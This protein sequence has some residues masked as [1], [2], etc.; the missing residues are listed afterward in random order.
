M[1]A[2]LFG[3]TIQNE[4]E[5]KKRGVLA[6]HDYLKQAQHLSTEDLLVLSEEISDEVDCRLSRTE[7]IPDSARRRS[8]RRQRSY[9]RS[10]GSAAP[11][12]QAVG[13]LNI[14]NPRV[15]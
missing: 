14:Y 13:L 15:A 9:R 12:I 11:P 8:I 6:M 2:P 7:T 1:Q 5:P 10:T 3:G 4:Y